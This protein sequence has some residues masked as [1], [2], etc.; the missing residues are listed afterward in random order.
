MPSVSATGITLSE[1]IRHS[2]MYTNLIYR[3]KRAYVS[4]QSGMCHR[5]WLRLSLEACEK[6]CELMVA[7][8]AI[9][10]VLRT[11]SKDISD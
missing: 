4:G 9:G 11:V 10:G 8:A 5:D 2:S 6:A 3:T 1:N 7:C